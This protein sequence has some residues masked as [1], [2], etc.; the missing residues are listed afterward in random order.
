MY[1]K[2]KEKRIYVTC[3]DLGLFCAGRLAWAVGALALA[4]AIGFLFFEFRGR[5]RGENNSL[6]YVSDFPR[7]SVVS[8][9][10]AAVVTVSDQKLCVLIAISFRQR[11]GER[12]SLVGL[13]QAFFL[14]QRH[15]TCTDSEELS[16]ALAD[17]HLV[18]SKKT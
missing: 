17:L 6:V 8:I 10:P 11:R 16:P 13:T 1:S 9:E 4:W 7:F 2:K 3:T 12:A 5:C 15:N 18:D 14:V